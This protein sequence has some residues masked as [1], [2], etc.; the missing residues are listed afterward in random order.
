ME[1]HAATAALTASLAEGARR[2]AAADVDDATALEGHLWLM[3]H[4][5]TVL[6]VFAHADPWCPTVMPITTR[7]RRMLGDHDLASYHYVAEIDA[8][9]TYRVTCEP[10]DAAFHSI[11]VQRGLP[12]GDS[13]EVVG[14]RNDREVTRRADGSFE[15]V[16]SATASDGDWIDIGGAPSSI[17]L[18]QFFDTASPARREARW[19]IENLTPKPARRHDDVR[20]AEAF[21]R[22]TEVVVAAIARYPLPADRALFAQ[23]G[24]NA[25]APVTR[26]A[27]GGVPMWGNTDAYHTTMPYDLGP[28]EALAIDGGA[29][30][31]CAWW[32]LT[33][34]NRFLAGFGLHENACLAG[35][36]VV[37]RPDGTWRAVLSERD[38]LV[39]NWITPAGHRNAILRIRWLV[40][41][42]EPSVP[43]VRR[44]PLAA[45]RELA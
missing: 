14:K 26:F 10:G 32:G 25:F 29:I 9:C 37:A 40:A 31:P 16:L 20:L 28:D 22:A 12:I 33:Q 24:V 15:V 38:P 19:H 23:G 36:A 45:V 11:T 35:A 3:E 4:A 42:G 34:N 6:E 2:L 43:T 7:F 27:E 1:I 18:R 39:P 21:R 44:V 41:D 30:V 13:A 17:L 8:S 5:A